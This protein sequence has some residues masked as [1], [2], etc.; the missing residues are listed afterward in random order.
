MLKK[1]QFLIIMLGAIGCE[2]DGPFN[3]TLRLTYEG[4]TIVYPGETVNIRIQ[5]IRPEIEKLEIVFSNGKATRGSESANFPSKL[6]FKLQDTSEILGF[7]PSEPGT[8]K[9]LA[10]YERNKRWF[11][12]TISFFVSDREEDL[13]DSF[14][15]SLTN[16]KLAGDGHQSVELAVASDK[17]SGDSSYNVIVSSVRPIIANGNR[18]QQRMQAANGKQVRFVL[19]GLES[20]NIPL[21]VEITRLSGQLVKRFDT[22]LL[23][24][25]VAPERLEFSAAFFP[26]KAPR[27]TQIPFEIRYGLNRPGLPSLGSIISL[28]LLDSLQ[29]PIND[30]SIQTDKTQFRTTA[31]GVEN[32][33]L[34]IGNAYIG[35]KFYIRVS[36]ALNP[37]VSITQPINVVHRRL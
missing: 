4:K 33:K 32:L 15:L 19:S 1:I 28:T 31:T 22:N 18:A 6:I 14:S 23:F 10:R 9:V 16:N 3:N 17:P 7:T 13:K 29:N 24:T 21:R 2:T 37:S 11:E 8:Y 36:S 27:E 34:Y 35:T 5:T 12:D 30:N 26:G 25:P 20:D